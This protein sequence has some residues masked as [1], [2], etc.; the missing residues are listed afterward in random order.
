MKFEKKKPLNKKLQS[1]AKKKPIK[2]VRRILKVSKKKK[3]SK[4]AQA[5]KKAKRV[6]KK[7][8]SKVIRNKKLKVKKIKK[9]VVKKSK[10][11]LVKSNP[12]KRSVSVKTAKKTLE[13]NLDFSPTNFFKARI[14]VIGIGG[15]G[16][17]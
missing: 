7:A 13:K 3:P 4:K 14:K 2:V 16:G 5:L 8:K 1:S 6:F 15:G 11:L 10:P 17:V 12:I 9:I